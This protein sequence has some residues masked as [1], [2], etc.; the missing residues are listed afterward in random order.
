MKKRICAAFL[1]CA[2]LAAPCAGAVDVVIPA[3]A[4]G[5]TTVTVDTA[6]DPLLDLFVQEMTP[7][8]LADFLAAQDPEQPAGSTLAFADI[9]PLVQADNLTILANEQIIPASKAQIDD[10]IEQ[11]EDG[12]DA[13]EDGIDGLEA[14]EAMYDGLIGL[15]QGAS[16]TVGSDMEALLTALFGFAQ[17]GQID[18]MQSGGMALLLM[19]DRS[20]I[21]SQIAQLEGQIDD[22]EDQIEELE[23][24]D[25]D[26]AER[27]LDAAVDQITMGAET[28]YIALHTMQSGYDSLLRQEAILNMQLTTM[29]KRHELGQ[30][31]AVDVAMV[32]DG[33]RQLTRGKENL[34]MTMRNSRGDLNLLLG[35]DMNENFTLAPLPAVTEAQILGM[36]LEDDLAR[37]MKNSFAVWQAEEALDTAKDGD[38]SDRRYNVKQ[39]EYQLESA[40]NSFRLAFTKLFRA[41]ED[42]TRAVQ[43]ARDSRGFKITELNVAKTK[44]EL[45]KISY[46][47]YIEAQTNLAQADADLAA[48]ENDLFLAYNNYEWAKRGVTA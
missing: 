25:F 22:L 5:S 34:E 13:L 9:A 39:A 48:A 26:S 24:T 7:Q 23:D 20:S 45:G 11:M 3:P 35:R 2:L 33:L 43:A 10:A 21:A 32:R 4:G 41:V 19:S 30:V 47:E 31:S 46:N 36:D 29:E 17:G 6:N 16:G 8:Q 27:Q 14:M 12:I 15:Y 37:G 44:Y 40:E 42:G 38:G 28:L 18:A 1:A